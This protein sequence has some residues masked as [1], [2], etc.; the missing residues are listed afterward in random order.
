MHWEATLPP[1][2]I[3]PQ[4]PIS[5]YGQTKPPEATSPGGSLPNP[6]VGVFPD[7]GCFTKSYQMSA[8]Q[9]SL[10]PLSL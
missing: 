3:A 4:P 1:L 6:P 5:P 10:F 8:V 2:A 7:K 9:V